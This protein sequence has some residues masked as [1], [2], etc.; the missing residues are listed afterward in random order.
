MKLCNP[1]SIVAN[2]KDI[3]YDGV[4]KDFL[5]TAVSRVGSG[6]IDKGGEQENRF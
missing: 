5:L 1:G 2:L 3:Q 4:D 6:H